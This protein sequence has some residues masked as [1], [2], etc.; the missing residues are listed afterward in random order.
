MV[1]IW[2]SLG[3]LALGLAILFLP[4]ADVVD[5]VRQL[6]LPADI[7]RLAIELV[8]EQMFAYACLAAAP[9]LLILGSILPGL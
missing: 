5:V 6:G 4:A 2:L 7:Q 3:L 1:T 9:I 8:A